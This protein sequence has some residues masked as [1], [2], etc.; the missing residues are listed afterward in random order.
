MEKR[1]DLSVH[2]LVDFLLRTGDIDSRIYNKTSM[3]EGTRLHASYQRRQSSEYMPEYFLSHTFE[4]DDFSVTLSGRAD[5]IIERPFFAIIDEIKTSVID[6]EE[7]YKSQKEWHLGQAKVYALIYAMD[8][9]FSQMGVRLTYINQLNDKQ[10]IKEFKYSKDELE[11]YV[12]GLIRE[13]LNFYQKIFLLKEERNATS[14]TLQFPFPNFRKGQRELAKYT[15][16]TLDKG[17]VL[18]VEAPTGIGKTMSTLYPAI[19]TFANENND[20]IFYLTAKNSGIESAFIAVNLLL[21]R[22]LKA[23]VIQITAK[24]KICACLG[25]NCN[26]DDCPF[27]KGYYEKLRKALTDALFS[28]V[29][30]SKDEVVNIALNHALCPFEFQLDLSLF[31]DVVICDFN[32][33]FDPLVYLRR[34]FDS[35]N[36]NSVALV[37]EVHNLVE[38][39]RKMYSTE[40]HYNNFKIAKKVLGKH[41]HKKLKSAINKLQKIFKAYDLETDEGYNLKDNID[42]E[43]IHALSNFQKAATDYMK[44]VPL[45]TK[46][47]FTDFF[48]EAIRFIKISDFFNETFRFMIVKENNKLIVSIINLDPSRLLK[49]SLELLRGAVLFSATLSP[50]DYYVRMLGGNDNSPVLKIQSPFNQDNL[51]LMIAPSV[52]TTYKK[53]DSTI[54][55]VANYIKTMV[56]MKI[57][58]YFVFFP[59]YKYLNNVLRCF[60]D[61]N[62]DIHVQTSEMSES[63]KN[64]FLD[65]FKPNPQNTHVGFVVLGGI[66]SEGIDLIDDRLIG[67]VIV[68][69]GLPQ[70][71][72]ERDLI[73][74]YF[75]KEEENGFEFAYVKPGMNRVIQAVGRVIRSENDIGAVLLID[76]R[77]LQARYRDLF[78]SEWDNYE[79]VLNVN[80]VKESLEKFYAHKIIEK[81]NK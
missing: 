52:A 54:E 72:F 44:K 65:Y 49:D 5:G 66:F 6:N 10:L 27:A 30:Y 33:L 46:Q 2:Q 59:S 78:K 7:F 14:K 42:M 20:K 61:A 40:L 70:I 45:E 26:P 32:Y 69:V 68:G 53:R 12:I 71:S 67:A 38:R 51:H 1:L 35:P 15:Y 3:S 19:K 43:L 29:P 62:Y 41:E 60:E 17:E 37:D 55:E 63:E 75:D 81:N 77:Y 58:N 23:K 16:S 21:N 34:Y 76:N 73:K 57:G 80:D 79:V 50:L 9:G 56:D 36:K 39:G 22:G 11:I 24:E 47:E 64:A 8:N 31:C 25:R 4:V 28:N 74:D 18:F 13:Y 48:F